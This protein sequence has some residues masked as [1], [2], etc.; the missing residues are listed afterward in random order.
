MA[1][2]GVATCGSPKAMCACIRQ[3]G[4]SGPHV[5]DCGGCYNDR[6]I[7]FRLPMRAGTVSPSLADSYAA[8]AV[9]SPFVR[10][11]SVALTGLFIDWSSIQT[12]I[13]WSFG[14]A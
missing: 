7:A 11:L 2:T 12:C 6:G 1:T 8:S 14:W 9:E 4:H 13:Q 10:G 5:C 3:P